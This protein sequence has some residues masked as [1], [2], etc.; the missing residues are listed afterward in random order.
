MQIF[1][2]LNQ[3]RVLDVDPMETVED[4][5]EHIM[6]KEGISKRVYYLIH[7]GKIL[8]EGTLAENN[9]VHDSTILIIIRMC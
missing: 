8:K 7:R 1:I 4:L 2:K 6:D 9:I 3:T 5:H